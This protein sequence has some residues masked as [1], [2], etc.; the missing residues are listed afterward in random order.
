MRHLSIDPNQIDYSAKR[1][2]YSD[3]D[4]KNPDDVKEY[5]KSLKRS[6]L[7]DDAQFVDKDINKK[8]TDETADQGREWEQQYLYGFDAS[9]RPTPDV[10]S[11][12]LATKGLKCHDGPSKGDIEVQIFAGDNGPGSGCVK[13]I[14]P[15]NYWGR[16]QHAQFLV[17]FVNV[18]E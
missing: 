1:R 2:R 5:V 4:F 18:G 7:H 11:S 13:L 16:G 9:G 6:R 14:G 12:L 3:Y 10:E 15:R 17:P 8:R